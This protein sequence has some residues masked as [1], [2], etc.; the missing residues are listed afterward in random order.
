MSHNHTEVCH[1]WA[2][3]NKA[4]G[5]GFNVYFE[6]RSLYSYGSHYLLGFRMG[7]G[8][9]F[10]N[11]DSYSISTSRH[12][13]FAWRAAH[14]RVYHVPNLTAHRYALKTIARYASPGDY[15]A[16]REAAESAA[17]GMIRALA[18]ALSD[19]AD[20]WNGK[21][22][23]AA[24]ET[25]AE[26]AGMTPARTRDAIDSA[27]KA[28]SRAAVKAAA[29][30]AAANRQAAVAFAGVAWN[31]RAAW[32]ADK[33]A[34]LRKGSDYQARD[35][36]HTIE[37]AGKVAF[38]HHKAAKRAGLADSTVARI[39]RVVRAYRAAVADA[40]AKADALA[41]RRKF[42][43][44]VRGL[45][46]SL[47]RLSSHAPEHTPHA[48]GDAFNS[49]DAL[50]RQ[51]ATIAGNRHVKA[52]PALLAAMVALG[53]FAADK[54]QAILVERAR[55][56]SERK[57][58][59]VAKWRAGERV[60]H[61]YCPSPYGGAMIRAVDVTRDAAGRIDGGTLETSQGASVPLPHAIK[62]FRFVKL[63]KERGTGWN[64]N[65]VSVRVGHY[66]LDSIR[67][68]GGFT[69]GCHS[70]AWP[71]IEALALALGVFNLPASDSAVTHS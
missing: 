21:A 46:E 36:L 16:T 30:E 18:P 64:R 1:L 68:D 17:L 34:T 9:F 45:R 33:V 61:F 32:L 67:A 13:T 51:T 50:T 65:G 22:S 12:K 66:S 43:A 27:V 59:S 38:G 70:F 4:S 3:G 54:A 19:T 15:P 49:W 24:L 23:R 69:A 7:P 60:P 53:A 55:E 29:N 28:A 25:L 37:Y 47:V 57:A 71:E 8:L 20:A 10:L 63:C 11:S 62:A 52:R 56:E 44:H 42:H 40:N 31:V 39:W 5:K 26:C 2:S 48:S 6:G 35:A 14:G 58:A 41:A